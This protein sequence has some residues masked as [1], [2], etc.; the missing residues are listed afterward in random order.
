MSL[1]P[2]PSGTIKIISNVPFSNN[3][4]HSIYFANESDQRDYFKGKV[5]KTLDSQNY[6][7]SENGKIRVKLDAN[8][9]QD[10]S[11]LMWE[12]PAINETSGGETHVHQA[13][14]CY[15]FIT[16]IDFVSANVSEIT[17]EIDVIQTYLIPKR[18]KL[19]ECYIE[20]RHTTSDEVGEHLE[21]EPIS[22]SDKVYDHE[23]VFSDIDSNYSEFR[24]VM[25]TTF[26]TA[27]IAKAP[28]VA[29]KG[30]GRRVGS[31]Q[32]LYCTVFSNYDSF[33]AFMDLIGDWDEE[34]YNFIMNNIV[35]VI[36]IPKIFAP[37]SGESVAWSP[38][39]PGNSTDPSENGS[40]RK[41]HKFTKRVSGSLDGYTPNNKKLYTFPYNNFYLTNN[42]GGNQI[43]RYEYFSGSM[44]FRA[45]AAVQP[46]FEIVVYPENYA[47]EIGSCDRGVSLAGYPQVPW[48]S[49]AYKQWL[50]TADLSYKMQGISTIAAGIISGMQGNALG[51]GMS[52][53]NLGR[54]QS[55]YSVEKNN[56]MQ[57]SNPTHMGASSA[58]TIAGLKQVIGYQQ[59]VNSNDARRIDDYF[60]EFGYAVGK[61]ATPNLTNGR[62]NQH[63]IKT[64]G[65]LAVGGCPSEYL[66]QIENIFNSGI[67]FWKDGTVVG[68]YN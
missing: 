12:N 27:D 52:V 31:F 57:A 45:Y 60:T 44:N 20:R 37:M 56:A 54:L 36:A 64:V 35:S 7:K 63:Y 48:M 53:M 67:T 4:S 58:K 50:G 66:R 13:D 11:Y 33:R 8:E 61:I 49:S 51:V 29:A 47:G 65:C 32:G 21:P 15:A 10:A 59:C 6:V 28:N 34:T 2:G 17:Y 19:K 39:Y 5:L 42:D 26:D 40:Y 43:F 62:K 1:I 23:E 3:Y 38:L 18:A 25:W 24:P 55:S 9:I 14:W 46:N 41:D 30:M 22:F 68:N 16:N